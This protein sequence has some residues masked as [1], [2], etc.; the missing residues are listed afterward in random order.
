MVG[1]GVIAAAQALG[2]LWIELLHFSYVFSFNARLRHAV[3]LLV[4][5]SK[6]CRLH[7]NAIGAKHSSQEWILENKAF[8]EH[9]WPGAI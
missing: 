8:D 6:S 4:L 7:N 3:F 9:L 2:L 1:M 5:I